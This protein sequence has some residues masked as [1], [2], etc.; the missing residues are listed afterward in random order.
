MSI[1]GRWHIVD[2]EVWDRDAIDLLGP[3]FIEIGNHNQELTVGAAILTGI[4]A[5]LIDA[6]EAG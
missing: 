6:L 3:A 4:K 5:K 1:E 2:M